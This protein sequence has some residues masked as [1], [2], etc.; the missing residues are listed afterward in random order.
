MTE[1]ISHPAGRSEADEGANRYDFIIVGAGSAGCVLAN[2]LTEDGRHRVL[3]LEAGGRNAEFLIGMP[4]G[5][6]EL[7]K[8]KSRHNWGFETEPVPGL[9][10]RRLFWPRGKGW[11]GSSSIN[12]ML[13]VRGQ[14][15]RCF[16]RLIARGARNRL[17]LK[18]VN[19]AFCQKI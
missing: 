18:A 10:G 5:I 11:G 4:A 16:R 15:S 2:R 8:A 1:K 14:R 12:G 3:L 9:G 19:A 13:S 6:G 17:V 7:V